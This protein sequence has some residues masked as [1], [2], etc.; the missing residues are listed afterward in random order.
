MNA[1]TRRALACGVAMLAMTGVAKAEDIKIGFLGGITGPIESLVP[2]IVDG[3]QL[4]LRHINEQGGLLGGNNGV[5]VI[6]DTTCADATK[7]ADAADRAVNVE[8]VVA[9]VGALCSGATISAAN[10]AAIPGGVVM[11][12]P[13]STSPAITSMDDKDLV[14][15]TATSDAYQGE[16]LARLIAKY[17]VSEIAISYVNND[18][19]KGLADSLSN[20]FPKGGGKVAISEPHEDGKADYRSELGALAASGTTN[21][22]IIGYADGSGGTMLRQALEGGDFSM[23]FS[24]DGMVSDKIATEIGGQLEGKM[25]LT[26]PGTPDIPGA[27]NFKTLAEEAG[28]KADGVFVANSYDAAFLIGLAIEKA[29][30][31][32]RAAI[33][34][35]LRDVATAPGEVILPGEWSKAVAAI[36]DGK[37]INYEGATGSI[38][39]DAAGDVSSV[40]LETVIK[41]GKV[42][43]LGLAE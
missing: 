5:L 20:A 37:D 27:A 18:Y 9:I 17:G 19:G 8:K 1:V 22:V 39:F 24:A 10:N 11:I 42:T 32:D 29:G 30:S 13:A 28:I 14:Y 41:D 6:G 26:K 2:P 31:T 12:S 23:F 25:V 40:F 34:A 38:E 43:E 16:V 33:A 15:R 7:A 35:A 36:K 4:A 3:A 21:L